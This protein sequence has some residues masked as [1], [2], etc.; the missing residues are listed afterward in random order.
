[1]A[2]GASHAD[3]SDAQRDRRKRGDTLSAIA[4]QFNVSLASLEVANPLLGAGQLIEIG[5][6]LN[7]PRR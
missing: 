4:V 5:S 7:I 2:A 3:R 1:M 6:T